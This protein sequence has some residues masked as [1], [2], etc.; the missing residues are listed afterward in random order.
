M[1][2][3]AEKP[4]RLNAKMVECGERISST[5]DREPL[6]SKLRSDSRLRAELLY[7]RGRALNVGADHDPEAENLLSKAVKLDPAMIEAWNE[8]GEA[9]WKRNDVDTAKTCFEGAVRLVS[10][11]AFRIF[12]TGAWVLLNKLAVRLP[13]T[14]KPGN[15]DKIIVPYNTL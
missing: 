11:N 8:L 12:F 14:G 15:P 13:R 9:H 3:A 1:A 7:H 6:C 10:N 5:A 2:E 4:S